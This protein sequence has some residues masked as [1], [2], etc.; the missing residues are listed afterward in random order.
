MQA[1]GNYQGSFPVYM[2]PFLFP[3]FEIVS[4][5]VMT[6]LN[7]TIFTLGIPVWY[8]EPL[9][10]PPMPQVVLN[11]VQP[12]DTLS[13]PPPSPPKTPSI[14]T[15][16]SPP[17][18]KARSKSSKVVV[19]PRPTPPCALC[20]VH[21]HATQKIPRDTYLV[22]TYRC[23]GY[24]R[25]NSS[26]HHHNSSNGQ[27]Q[28]LKDK[29]LIHDLWFIQPLFAPLPRLGRISVYPSWYLETLSWVED[30]SH[31]LNSPSSFFLGHN[32]HHLHDLY[33]Q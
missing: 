32:H 22:H 12:I 31:R 16:A 20:D 3:P 24:S 2:I 7:L 1:L 26:S 27:E 9:I 6:T 25:R 21:G 29:P 14:P 11:P 28:V 30:H 5:P 19:E 8:L 18:K 23:Y 4:K 10:P 17:L 33:F 15:L 13:H